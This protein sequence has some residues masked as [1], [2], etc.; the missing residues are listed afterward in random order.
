[1]RALAPISTSCGHA[2]P[3]TGPGQEAIL[4]RP[5]RAINRHRLF[6]AVLVAQVAFSPAFASRSARP[7]IDDVEESLARDRSFKVRVEAALIL[8]RLGQPR[9][10]PVLI[11]A[12]R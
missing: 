11:G 8:G 6:L 2:T 3:L 4:K 1:M 9:S 7:R 10:V 12:L 5:V